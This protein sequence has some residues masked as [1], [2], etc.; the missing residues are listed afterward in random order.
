SL[1]TWERKKLPVQKSRVGEFLGGEEFF[2]EAIKKF[3][4][5]KNENAFT[6]IRTKKERNLEIEEL[7]QEFEKEK[8][9]D[10]KKANFSKNYWKNLR[11]ELLVFLHD[12]Y[13]LTYRQIS[14][15][16]YFKNLQLSSLG[17][18]YKREKEKNVKKSSTVPE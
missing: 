8:N 10:F 3:D 2:K 7:I 13:L 18:I 4:R 1:K 5:R 17:T 6:N 14:K 12:N 15:I 9:I 11:A 16:K